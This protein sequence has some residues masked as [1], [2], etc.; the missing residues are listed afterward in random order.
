MQSAER[1]CFQEGVKRLVVAVSP[2]WNVGC[3]SFICELFF[4]KNK[5]YFPSDMQTQGRRRRIIHLCY[6]ILLFFTH[7]SLDHQLLQRLQY[8]AYSASLKPCVIGC[9]IVTT[10]FF[11]LLNFSSLCSGLTL[12]GSLLI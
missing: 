9:N 8:K 12:Y 7:G 2:L 11:S 4:K 3:S 10:L 5:I 1:H 6:N